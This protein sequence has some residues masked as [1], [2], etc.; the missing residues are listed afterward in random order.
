MLIE[1]FGT[2][3]MY[4]GSVINFGEATPTCYSPWRHLG[5]HGCLGMH[6]LFVPVRPVQ[7]YSPGR[8]R[9][10]P[11]DHPSSPWKQQMRATSVCVC[12]CVEYFSNDPT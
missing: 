3:Y 8:G 5:D 6:A 1:H 7:E 9:E 12:V 11:D 2:K 10:D 4:Y